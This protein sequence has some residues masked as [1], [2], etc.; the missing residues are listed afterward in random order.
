MHTSASTPHVAATAASLDEY[1]NLRIQHYACHLRTISNRFVAQMQT[2]N[3]T[4]PE[5]ICRISFRKKSTITTIARGAAGDRH[6]RLS[7]PENHQVGA[8][9]YGVPSY[10]R[11]TLL[12]NN[13]YRFHVGMDLHSFITNCHITVQIYILLAYSSR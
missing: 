2:H 11:L 4:E 7:S 13:D 12:C 8:C 9:I 10:L 1:S 3:D 6:S 5:V